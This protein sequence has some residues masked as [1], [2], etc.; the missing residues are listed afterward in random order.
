MP[1]P[2]MTTDS[3]YKTVTSITGEL[4]VQSLN[5]IVTGFSF[6]SALAWLDVV[7]WVIANVIKVK[8]NS[9]AHYLITALATTLLS[10]IV[11]MIVSRISKQVEKP[12]PAV[13]AVTR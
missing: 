9:S 5:S 3:V 11:Y 2:L 8:N 10:V 4:Q 7:R 6:A 12:K 1:L 13:Y